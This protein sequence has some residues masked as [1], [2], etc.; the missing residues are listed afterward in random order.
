MTLF[1]NVIFGCA[2]GLALAWTA[3][4]PL[5]QAHYPSRTR[6]FVATMLY[7]GAALVP[8]GLV[9]F[10]LF[11]DWS[12][13]Y[14]VNPSQLSWFLMLPVVVAACFGAPI[15]GF[16]V[17]QRFI[18]TQRVEAIGRVLLSLGIAALALVT[19]G[20]GALTKVGYYEAYHYG[21]TLVPLAQSPVLVALVSCLGV[22]AVLF[23]YTQ[24]ALAAHV[25]AL[26]DVEEG[27]PVKPGVVEPPASTP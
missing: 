1:L 18:A 6:Y 15:L 10:V 5:A 26:A 9:L 24:R 14:V 22:L 8:A 16:F 12:L 17:G 20:W 2:A 13:M 7:A 25:V 19:L 11:P 23:V 4:S 27:R 3:R 21:G